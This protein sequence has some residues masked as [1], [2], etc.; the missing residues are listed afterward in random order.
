MEELFST[1][2]KKMTIYVGANED[3]ISSLNSSFSKPLPIDFLSF[4]K[5]SNGAVGM[6]GPNY[7]EICKA[8]DISKLNEDYVVDTYAPGL[9]LFGTDG[10]GEGYG[11]DYRGND[12]IVVEIP[13]V[14]MDWK[15][16]RKKG[17]TFLDFLKNLSM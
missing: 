7:L 6:I 12:P 3:Q 1:L 10:G 4:L 8:E 16:A 17:D 15:E 2:T 5:F 13:F 14:G 11:F 9:I